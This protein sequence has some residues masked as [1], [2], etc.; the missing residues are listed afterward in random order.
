[1][2]SIERLGMKDLLTENEERCT[3]TAACHAVMAHFA[4]TAETPKKAW[5]D[6]NTWWRARGFTCEW[7]ASHTS[8][9]RSKVKAGTYINEYRSWGTDGRSHMHQG[10]VAEFDDFI[11]VVVKFVN[12]QHA[13]DKSVTLLDLDNFLARVK[14]VKPTH[15]Q[16][17][18]LIMRAHLRMGSAA[19]STLST[20]Q[21]K[22]AANAL[23]SQFEI[24]AKLFPNLD[25]ASVLV[26]MD[27][28][29]WSVQ[30]TMRD[31]PQRTLMPGDAKCARIAATCMQGK[32]KLCT[33]VC[34]MSTT[35]IPPI[36]IVHAKKTE[37]RAATAQGKDY[38][39]KNLP[40]NA[41]D[42]AT[43]NDDIAAALASVAAQCDAATANDAIAV[44]LAN[45]KNVDGIDALLDE[46]KEAAL[47][48]DDDGKNNDGDD[49]DSAAG[50][51]DDNDDGEGGDGER[52]NTQTN[53]QEFRGHWRDEK[54]KQRQRRVDE[55]RAKAAQLAMAIEGLNITVVATK[56]ACMTAQLLSEFVLAHILRHKKDAKI[57][58]LDHATSHVA[59]L[60]NLKKKLVCFMIPRGTTS[61][62]Q[63][64]DVTF[65]APFK[66]KFS[67]MLDAAIKHVGIDKFRDV[68]IPTSVRL[69]IVNHTLHHVWKVGR[70]PEATV[71]DIF[72]KLGYTAKD[73]TDIKLNIDKYKFEY[74]AEAAE[75]KRAEIM[76][77]MLD[78]RTDARRDDV[79]VP[80]R[81]ARPGRA[82]A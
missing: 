32:Y 22:K 40:V 24:L 56:G 75:T 79:A 42:A 3:P 44:A 8:I 63:A 82:A 46:A 65:F 10:R 23:L 43:A 73:K 51:D 15:N 38:V 19:L 55:G 66:Q 69:R 25:I 45:V 52:K 61:V 57:L 47:G 80:R 20:E 76:Q 36:I 37:L 9:V 16:L 62:L 6:F 78:S 74:D 13:A 12:D 31:G 34:F 58:V 53:K 54:V 64:L 48:G 41:A 81:S 18:R 30:G 17:V 70:F 72:K 4:I 27:E 77:Q 50:S 28:S 67:T 60:E 33:V 14:G 39:I 71:R 5:I 49:S 26:Q 68:R 35:D 29:A 21:L 7:R 59:A 11:D 2:L 1:M